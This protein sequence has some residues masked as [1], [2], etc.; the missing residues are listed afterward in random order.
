MDQIVEK[1]RQL[2]PHL[3]KEAADFIDALLSKHASKEKKKPTLHW[4]GGLK[5]YKD[6]VTSVKL[7]KKASEWRD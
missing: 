4:I 3:L 7:Q 1:I 5:E 6:R 2:P